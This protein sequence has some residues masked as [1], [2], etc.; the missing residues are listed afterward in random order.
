MSLTGGPLNKLNGD[1]GIS[2]AENSV[3]VQKLIRIHNP[4]SREELV[5][6]IKKHHEKNCECGIKSKGT[7]EDFGNNLYEAQKTEWG[8]YKFSRE[9]CI[10]WEYHLFVTQSLIGNTIEKDVKKVL[11]NKLS[12]FTIEDS[13]SYYD[14][15]LR[16]DLVI[17]RENKIIV[18]IQV[19]PESFK[20][21]RG[22]VKLFNLKRNALVDFPVLYL[23]YEY[24]QR[25]IINLDEVVSR[26]KQDYSSL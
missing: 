21:V 19:K 5:D 26:I 15:E 4:S 10:E 7:I 2:A 14:E 6:L 12:N 1:C 13:G 22:N 16:I 9:E 23:Y 17:K 18:G 24:G 20:N 3:P 25:K 8:E 11:E